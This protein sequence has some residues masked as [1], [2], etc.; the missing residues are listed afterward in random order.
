MPALSERQRLQA[1][2][3]EQDVTPTTVDRPSVLSGSKRMTLFLACLA[4][5]ACSGCYRPGRYTPPDTPGPVELRPP[6]EDLA[7]LSELFRLRDGALYDPTVESGVVWRDYTFFRVYQF[8]QHSV[9]VYPADWNEDRYNIHMYAGQLDHN[10]RLLNFIHRKGGGKYGTY[11]EPELKLDGTTLG[12]NGIGMDGAFLGQTRDEY[13]DSVVNASN[14]G[15]GYYGGLKGLREH[16]ESFFSGNNNTRAFTRI[17]QVGQQP[18]P[19]RTIY[20]EIALNRE[21]VVFIQY[22]C[23][24]DVGPMLGQFAINKP[25]TP[26]VR[27]GVIDLS[28]PDIE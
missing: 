17:Y 26:I 7:R 28:Q 21:R 9:A 15:F 6:V 1:G 19:Y 3:R 11:F 27:S 23:P 16:Y 4:M 2:P 12:G 24:S 25:L 13:I 5:L 20:H 14:E 22:I 10:E 8:S 18:L